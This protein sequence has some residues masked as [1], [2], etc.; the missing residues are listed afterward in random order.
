[1]DVKNFIAWV[2]DKTD[3]IRELVIL[4]VGTIL[5]AAV[6]FSFFEDK[7]IWDSLWWAVVTGLTIGY[8]DQY[9]TTIGGRITT[10]V[11]AH[12]VILVI[13]PLVVGHVVTRMVKNQNEFTDSEQRKMMELLEKISKEKR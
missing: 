1:M 4:Y 6:S 8:G 9:P 5:A 3:T 13:I 10:F 7:S 11:L 12:L 2:K